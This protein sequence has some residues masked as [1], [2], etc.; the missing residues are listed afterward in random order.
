LSVECDIARRL[1][2]FDVLGKRGTTSEYLNH[3][4]PRKKNEW[5]PEIDLHIIPLVSNVLY[6]DTSVPHGHSQWQVIHIIITE[7]I[8]SLI[9]D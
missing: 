7:I 5:Y 4:E 3:Q 8:T 9:T 6:P 1:N 2:W